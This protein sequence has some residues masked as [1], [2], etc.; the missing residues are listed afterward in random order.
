MAAS[1]PLRRAA[2]DKN[3]LRCFGHGSPSGSASFSHRRHHFARAS[4]STACSHAR[5]SKVMTATAIF[6]A[7]TARP[8]RVA[9]RHGRADDARRLW[10]SSTTGGDFSARSIYYLLAWSFHHALSI[11]KSACR[12]TAMPTRWR[13]S[14][15]ATLGDA[16]RIA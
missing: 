10:A 2:A 11:I 4:I 16:K 7:S 15:M 5:R 1:R 13:R 8:A 3:D 6:I 9:L 14:K 12:R